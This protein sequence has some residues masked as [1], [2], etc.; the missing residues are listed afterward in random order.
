M[1]APSSNHTLRSCHA[2]AR[3]KGGFSPSG[4]EAASGRA[5]QAGPPSPAAQ[6]SDAAAGEGT[7][8]SGQAVA[9]HPPS[10]RR[11][12]CSSVRSGRGVIDWIM[13]DAG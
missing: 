9:R 5:G 8:P 10:P 11:G 6:N 2:G 12:T 7:L 4:R 13:S 1:H 3:P